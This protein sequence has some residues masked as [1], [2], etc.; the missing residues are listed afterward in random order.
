MAVSNGAGDELFIEFSEAGAIVK[1]FDHES[2]MSPHA[3]EEFAVWRG[4]LDDV[5]REFAGFLAEPAIS[6]ENT[7]FC[8][9][10]FWSQNSWQ[11]GQ[12]EFPGGDD[13]DGS[14]FLLQL[15]DGRPET[16]RDWAQD[17]YERPVD[18]EAVSLIYAHGPISAQTLHRL[19]P[20]VSL[21]LLANDLLEIGY[22]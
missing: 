17:Y 16:Y 15:F 9:W 3:N 8:F 11:T 12:V 6:I 1:G 13:P 5:P 7:T 19:N 4:V 14:A 10:R 18:L 20:E 22:G 21:E 2:T